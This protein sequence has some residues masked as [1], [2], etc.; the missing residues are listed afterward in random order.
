MKYLGSVSQKRTKNPPYHDLS[1]SHKNQWRNDIQR[2]YK[3]QVILHLEFPEFFKTISY[4]SLKYLN[5]AHITSYTSHFF[6]AKR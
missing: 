1:S 6:G 2:P 5:N 3:N 4:K